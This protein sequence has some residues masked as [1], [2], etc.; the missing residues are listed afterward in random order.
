MY[1]L[2]GLSMFEINTFLETMKNNMQTWGGYITMII[3]AIMMIA[4]VWQVGK[5]FISKN[6]QT[7]WVMAI[8]AIVLGGM[9]LAG[10]W[11]LLSSVS[12]T[13]SSELAGYG[14]GAFILPFLF[15]KK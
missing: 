5:G 3:G 6:G 15:C 7:N 13:V 10:S 2:E 1:G 14:G 8:G 4:G 11:M 12:D 9:L